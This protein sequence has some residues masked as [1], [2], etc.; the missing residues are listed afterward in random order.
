[1]EVKEKYRNPI[2]KYG[3]IDEE[4]SAWIDLIDFAGGIINDGMLIN[5]A[6]S[7]A[8]T[9][10]I[11]NFKGSVGWLLKFKARHELKL[12]KLHGESF[13]TEPPNNEDIFKVL[14]EKISFYGPEN[15]YNADETGLFYKLIPSKTLCKNVRNGYKI[16]KDRISV[17]LCANMTGTKKLKP[18]VI[19]KFAKPRCF[20][21]FP[22]ETYVKYVNSSRAW[23]TAEIFNKWLLE[24]DL[25]LYTT[26]KFFLLV[27]DNCP[28]HRVDVDLKSIEILFLPANLTSTLQPLDQ[29][30]INSLKTIFSNK[31][32]SDII[33][34]VESR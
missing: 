24:W 31:K 13:T 27:I 26:R 7:I 11:E 33:E 19:G 6:L 1:M 34:K 32:L 9:Q 23:M 15:V 8:K 12:R 10:K 4:L 14:N 21:Q 29:G 17:L 18:L 16:L 5:K 22:I 30:V 2:L 3:K 25:E 20:K 28:S